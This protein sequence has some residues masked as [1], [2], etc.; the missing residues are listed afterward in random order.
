ML[1]VLFRELPWIPKMYEG[2]L[3]SLVILLWLYKG[4]TEKSHQT[5]GLYATMIAIIVPI[6]KTYTV[7]GLR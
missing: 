3:P 4:L 5:Q 6:R 1:E 7:T 2:C